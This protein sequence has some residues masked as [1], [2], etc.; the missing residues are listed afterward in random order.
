MQVSTIVIDSTLK[1]NSYNLGI[2]GHDFYMQNSK[3]F[4]YTKYNTA[5]KLVVQI[6]GNGSLKKRT[7]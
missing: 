4:A 6:I 3:Y 7:D 2:N 1:V 5:P